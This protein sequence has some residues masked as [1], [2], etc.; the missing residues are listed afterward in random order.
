MQ[1]SSQ[2]REVTVSLQGS[3]CLYGSANLKWDLTLP[4]EHGLFERIQ[5][6]ALR[7]LDNSLKGDSIYVVPDCI[8]EE[9]TPRK[10]VEVW[11]VIWVEPV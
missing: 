9:R 6:L 1:T 4:P 5:N 11:P 3:V 8:F 2:Q 7:G 10:V